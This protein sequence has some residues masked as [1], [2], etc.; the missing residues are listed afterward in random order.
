MST[1]TI[2]LARLH[3]DT[4]VMHTYQ[5]V[6]EYWGFNLGLTHHSVVKIKLASASWTFYFILAGTLTFVC[7]CV[8][9]FYFGLPH[10]L[11]YHH[12]RPAHSFSSTSDSF[13]LCSP[14]FNDDE[15]SF[16]DLGLA[17]DHFS[18]PEVSSWQYY[19]HQSWPLSSNCQLCSN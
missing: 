7:V 2:E 4:H 10:S 15:F 12:G 14:D 5:L 9:F 6:S 8:C 11:G 16:A 3:T 17:E 13:S 19:G 18:R 1:E